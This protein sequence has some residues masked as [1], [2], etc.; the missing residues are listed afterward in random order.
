VALVEA[1]SI[2]NDYDLLQDALAELEELKSSPLADAIGPLLRII[3]GIDGARRAGWAKYYAER[4]AHEDTER[5]LAA[6]TMAVCE[7]NQY[8]ESLKAAMDANS[9]TNDEFHDCLQRVNNRLLR[10]W[11]LERHL[12]QQ[13]RSRIEQDERCPDA[14]FPEYFN[15]ALW[16]RMFRMWLSDAETQLRQ[17][18]LMVE[19]LRGHHER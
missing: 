1:M 6:Q 11:E 9:W 3:D 2:H 5:R 10:Q 8:V 14:E 15:L 18:D 4:E 17:S 13:F 19:R 7:R 12:F 16:I